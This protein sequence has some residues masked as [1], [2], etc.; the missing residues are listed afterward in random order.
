MIFQKFLQTEKWQHKDPAVRLEAIAELAQV[1]DLE[2]ADLDK[3][4]LIIIDLAR[5][6]SDE[7]VRVAAI[8]QLRSAD[9][10]EALAADPADA[11]RQ[12]AVTQLRRLISG[13]APSTLTTEQRLAMMQESADREALL[14]I[15]LDCGCDDI[16]QATLQRLRDEFALDEH[17]LADIAAQSTNHT[18]RFAAAQHVDS[19]EL[20]E[21]LANHA[22]LRDKSVFRHCRERLQARQ[23]EEARKAAAAARSLQI[24]EAVETM[25]GKPVLPL[26]MAQLDYKT[27]RWQE[28]CAEADESLHQRFNAASETLRERLAEHAANKQALALRRQQFDSIASACAKA[29][30][31]LAALS[32]P[33]NTEQIEELQQQV[34]A[35][36]AL[37]AEQQ[38]DPSQLLD[39]CRQTIATAERSISAFNVLEAKAEDLAALATEIGALTAK[40]TAALRRVQQEFNQLLDKE[41][42]PHALPHSALFSQSL[43][44]EQQLERLLERNRAYLD[45]LRS[46]S[47]AHIEAMQQHIE[48]GQVNEAQRMWDKVQGAIR[49]ADEALAAELQEKVSPYRASISELL[50]WKNFAANEKKKE[51]IGQMQALVDG[52]MHAAEQ[53]KRIK[54]LQEEWKTLGHSLHNDNLWQQFNELSHKAFEPCKE[55]FRERKAKLQGNLEARN[56]ICDELEALLPTLTTETVNIAELNKIESK[57]LEDWK[58]YA[59]VEQAKIK[60]LQKRF[61]TVLSDLRQFKRKT[62]QANAARKLALIAQAEQ[63]DAMEDV[64]EAMAEAKRLQ[65]EWKTIGPSPYRDDRNHWNAFRAACDKLFNKRKDAPRAARP[66]G[67]RQQSSAAAANPAVAAARETLRKIDDLLMLSSEELVQS[68]KQFHDLAEEFRNALTADLKHEKRALQDQFTR[69][70]KSFESRLRD[71]PDKKTLQLVDHVRTKA[72]FCARLEQ[73]ALAG[74]TI[75]DPDALIEQWQALGRLSDLMQEQALEQRFHALIQGVEARL[76]KKQARDNEEKAREICIAAEI[77]AA[78]DSPAEDKAL[79]MTVQLKQL[80][81]SFGKANKSGAQLLNELELQLLC[82]G[83]LDAASRASFEQRLG[84]AKGKV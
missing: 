21:T 16:G 78:L 53:A 40:G 7:A 69:L 24:C 44:T 33:L 8:A 81:N 77:N 63:L 29:T 11:V 64:S 54:A 46:E 65:A 49:N 73:D 3:A 32:A 45:K 35:I 50:A 79:R 62:L 18:V 28:V 30:A 37:M 6:D 1:P 84:V 17:Q 36:K 22:R 43:E 19:T 60:K 70:S 67:A 47:L 5:L 57:A 14:Q 23:E 72:E 20:L 38:Q 58:L 15:V 48:Q 10:L 2:A 41:S 42:W 4:S 52:E 9:V 56:K 83:P 31:T 75:D 61:N 39:H 55:Y 13:A 82:L 34:D 59:P 26:T 51:L 76:L 68:R 25:A 71:A 27:S 74:A 66:A 12:A 80:K